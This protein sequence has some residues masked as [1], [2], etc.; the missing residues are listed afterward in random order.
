MKKYISTIV[1]VSII[2]GIVI[3]MISQRDTGLKK[4][5][6]FVVGLIYAIVFISPIVSIVQ[7][8]D[9]LR[10]NISNMLSQVIDTDKIDKTNQIIVAS[11]VDK[12]CDGIKKAIINEY[13]FK[14]DSV[15]VSAIIDDKNL[16]AI[17]IDKIEITL[18]NE[19]TW[20]DG[21][22]VKSYVTD[23]VGCKVEVHKI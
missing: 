16:Q 6:S 13:N 9:V 17:V 19:A 3:N 11:S 23:L 10:E 12:I 4:Y 8:T 2:G 22:K 21:D 15:Q 18:L 14:E 1:L 5:I 20:Y 7:N